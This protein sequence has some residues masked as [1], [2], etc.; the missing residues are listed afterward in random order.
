MTLLYANRWTRKA[1]LVAQTEALR[2]LT[3]GVEFGAGLDVR[4]WPIVRLATGS[5]VVVGRNL[6]LVSSSYFSE[7]GVNHPC[8]IRTLRPGARIIVGDDVGMSGCSI[9]AAEEVTIGSCCLL[10][11]NAFITD[12]DFHPV[13]PENRRYRRENVRISPVHIGDNVFV[14]TGAMILKGVNIGENAVIGAGS[15]VTS[16]VPSNAVASGVP[17]RQVGTVTDD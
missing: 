9:C 12:S 7:P 13:E 2:A 6:T 3:P 15:V 5:R 10:G 1:L 17:A 8:V 4:G 16:D 11:A 14:G